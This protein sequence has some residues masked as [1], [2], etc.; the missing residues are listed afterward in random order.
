MIICVVVS[1]D[2]MCGVV[3]CDIAKMLT[4]AFTKCFLGVANMLFVADGA[5][6]AINDVIGLAV[7]VAYSVILPAC[8]RTDNGT[9]LIEFGAVPAG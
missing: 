6:D 8:N 7:T 4:Q 9:S 2:T 5:S 3:L 1:A